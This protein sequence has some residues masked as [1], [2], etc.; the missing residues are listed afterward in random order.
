MTGQL[1]LGNRQHTHPVNLRLLRKLVVAVIRELQGQRDYALGIYVVSA[2]EMARLNETFLRHSGPADVIT[3]DY[4]EP[5]ERSLHGEILVCIDVAIAQ[6]S[7]FRTSW[8]CELFRYVVHGLLHLHGFDDLRPA[9]RRKMKRVENRLVRQWARRVN[10][11][12][13][14]GKRLE[15]RRRFS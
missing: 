7:R 6:A 3:F 9:A 15:Q 12:L 2:R 11:D 8:S 4:A 5:P 13:L 14:A 1:S 10:L